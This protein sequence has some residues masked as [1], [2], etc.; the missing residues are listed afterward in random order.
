MCLAAV[1]KCVC[2]YVLP[3]GS[4]GELPQSSLMTMGAKA[5]LPSTQCF[6]MVSRTLW[7]KWMCRSHRNTMLWLSWKLHV[8]PS[9]V[10]CNK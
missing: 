1:S 4:R 9:P 7:G 3:S 5:N 2:V 6:L 10:A 8:I